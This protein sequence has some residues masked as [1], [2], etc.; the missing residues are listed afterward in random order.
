M[1]ERIVTARTFERPFEAH[2][3]RLRLLDEQI[4]CFLDNENIVT[5]YWLYSNAVGGVKLRVRESD[6]PRALAVLATRP[7]FPEGFDGAWDYE[8]ADDAPSAG[9]PNCGSD[10][11][12]PERIKGRTVLMLLLL[13]NP[14][15]AVLMLAAA[16]IARHFQPPRYRCN[17]CGYR[18]EAGPRGF[19]VAGLEDQDADPSPDDP[20]RPPDR[21]EPT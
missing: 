3:A 19:P 16:W 8:N 20:P 9:C 7:E 2:L 15:I 6:L 1:G 5:T 11:F 12:G 10:E 17:G 4:D 21:S 13:L 18:L 14:L